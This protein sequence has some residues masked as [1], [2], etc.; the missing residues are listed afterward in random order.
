MSNEKGG[1]VAVWLFSIFIL[2][3]Q[4]TVKSMRICVLE[5]PI[6]FCCFTVLD[7]H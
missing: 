6:I 4:F 2:L 1:L 7:N 3:V 5:N